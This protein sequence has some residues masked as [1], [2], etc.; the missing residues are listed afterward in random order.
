MGL[1]PAL[2][3]RGLCLGTVYARSMRNKVPALLNLVTIKGI[4]L[5]GIT[6]TWLTTSLRDTSQ[7]LAEMTPPP[8]R[9]S[10]FR[11]LEHGGGGW[12]EWVCLFQ[13][14]DCQPKQ[15][16]RLY[17]LNSKVVS[18]ALLSSRFIVHLFLLLLSSLIYKIF[19]ATYPHS[20]MIWPV[21]NLN[22][23]SKV[24]EKAVVNQQIWPINSS[25]KSNQYQSAYRKFHS[26]ERYSCINGC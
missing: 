19:C 18:H 17:L 12:G 1:Y 14:S 20:L 5:L 4:E 3:V 26:A 24:L 22:F 10:P 16:L 23:L 2:G 8:H 11:N 7:D 13:R 21:S 25:N 15:V 9:V 6:A